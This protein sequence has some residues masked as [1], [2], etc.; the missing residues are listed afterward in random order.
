MY[1]FEM[2]RCHNVPQCSEPLADS[3]FKWLPVRTFLSALQPGHW[4]YLLDTVA[5]SPGRPERL[6]PRRLAVCRLRIEH[7]SVR[8]PGRAPLAS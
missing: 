1:Y 7:A 4:H 2:I 8:G 6:A 5:R 3:E